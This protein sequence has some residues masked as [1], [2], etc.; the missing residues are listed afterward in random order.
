[1]LLKI[2]FKNHAC[3]YNE[4]EILFTKDKLK[5][6]L[7]KDNLEEGEINE[8]LDFQYFKSNVLMG[9]HDSGKTSVYE[10]LKTT[11]DYINHYLNYENDTRIR[12]SKNLMKYN[13][14]P[15]IL[16]TEEKEI[17]EDTCIE[18]YFLEK[19]YCYKYDLEFNNLFP[20]IERIYYFKG[21]TLPLRE[22]EWVE[23]YS[24]HN[25]E[26]SLGDGNNQQITCIFDTMFSLEDL[27]LAKEPKI[28]YL[29]LKN[30]IIL[31]LYT[32][33]KNIL[34]LNINK[35]IKK[36]KFYKDST[37]SSSVFK[38]HLLPIEYIQSNKEKYLKAF[39]KLNVNIVDFKIIDESISDYQLLISKEDANGNV[40]LLKSNRESDSIKRLF[41]IL[42]TI[43]MALESQTVLIVDD[44]NKNL[45]IDQLNYL[46]N[47]FEDKETNPHDSQIFATISTYSNYDFEDVEIENKY[48]ID[49]ETNLSSKIYKL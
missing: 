18:L 49:K 6:K 24:K 41:H 4:Q 40:H 44:L 2:K 39:E 21:K 47:L 32:Y 15:Y 30:S 25:L 5:I 13:Y 43:F 7:A 19:N 38:K 16:N 9:E 37:I 20:S 35:T 22:K 48:Q 34:T 11:F 28:N 29:D 17:V 1:M 36:V 31:H 42:T 10:L 8:E 23:I 46:L 27:D 33:A 45:T 3:F 12:T 26:Y 14:N